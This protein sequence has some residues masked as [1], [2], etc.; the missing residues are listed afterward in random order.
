MNA[1]QIDAAASA[2]AAAVRAAMKAAQ[3]PAPDAG[4]LMTLDD[5]MRELQVC[6]MTLYRL[7]AR[8]VLPFRHIGRSVRVLRADVERLAIEGWSAA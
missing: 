1:N 5:A 7:S 3:P 6:R 8:G 2:A 4:M